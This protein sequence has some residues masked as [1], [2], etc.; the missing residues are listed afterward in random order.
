MKDKFN[1]GKSII[2]ESKKVQQDT[3]NAT[4][5]PY[6][7]AIDQVSTAEATAANYQARDDI[8]IARYSE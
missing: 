2:D 5:K 6:Q 8:D 7:D 4:Y 3:I 1:Y